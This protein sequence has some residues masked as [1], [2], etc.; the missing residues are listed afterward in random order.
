VRSA[1]TAAVL[2]AARDQ[3]TS[4]LGHVGARG[5][6]GRQSS[7]PSAAPTHVA[8]NGRDSPQCGAPASPCSTLRFAVNTLGAATVLL[9]PGAFGVDSCG[10][11]AG[12]ALN[13]TGA[14]SQVT[15]IDCRGGDRALSAL[16]SV[17]LAGLT[18]RGGAVS[19][20]TSQPGGGAGVQVVWPPLG[21]GLVAHLQ[22]VVLEDNH[23]LGTLGDPGDSSELAGGGMFVM[24][25]LSN[26]SVS[27]V[28]CRLVGNS[29]VGGFAP[30]EMMS[31]T[32]C[33]GALFLALGEG[34]VDEPS[35]GISIVMDGGKHRDWG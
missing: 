25:G 10:T 31:A 2:A 15:T 7:T 35:T 28:G 17:W 9:G 1:A 29:V 34:A 16:D 18:I 23:V 8:T 4:P 26:L 12:H 20:N 30:R 13:L 11:V 6:P 24:G 27:L 14:G 21:S 3:A 22:D 19:L 33:G 32:L 5:L